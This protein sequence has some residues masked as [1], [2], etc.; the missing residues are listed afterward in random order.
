MKKPTSQKKLTSPFPEV[1]MPKT[2]G[3]KLESTSV[4]PACGSEMEKI[5]VN[6]SKGEIV[7]RVC[8]QHRVCLPQ[9][10][11]QSQVG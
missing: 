6:G 4:C 7:T 10:S 1:A 2:V 11:Q 8:F 3:A 5:L 9:K